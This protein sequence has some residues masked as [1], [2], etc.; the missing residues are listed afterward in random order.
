MSASS[1]DDE[2][3]ATSG[4]RRRRRLALIMFLLA[5]PAGVVAFLIVSGSSLGPWIAAVVVFVFAMPY[6]AIRTR[7]RGGRLF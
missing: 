5:I 7:E 6:T 4:T 2:T 1:D 3:K